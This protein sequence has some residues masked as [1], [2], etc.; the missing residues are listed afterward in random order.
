MAH[1]PAGEA[2]IVTIARKGGGLEV[3]MEVKID[4]ERGV[5][6]SLVDAWKDL[7]EAAVRCAEVGGG[8]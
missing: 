3:A 4:G 1:D 6:E 7:V 8:T 5:R 2:L